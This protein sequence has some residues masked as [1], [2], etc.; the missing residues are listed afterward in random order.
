MANIS[1]IQL[2]NGTTYNIEDATARQMTLDSIYT[3]TSVGSG[4]GDLELLF[5]TAVNGDNQ[6]F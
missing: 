3:E 2:P 1:Q 6:E 4:V 5:V